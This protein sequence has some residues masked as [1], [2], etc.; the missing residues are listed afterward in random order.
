MPITCG[1]PDSKKNLYKNAILLYQYTIT[2]SE[3]STSS[4]ARIAF[5]LHTC[6]GF[7]SLLLRLLEKRRISQTNG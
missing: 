1:Y 5:K 2:Y 6:F 7:V 4:S 3:P